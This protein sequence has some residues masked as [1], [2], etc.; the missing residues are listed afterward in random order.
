MPCASCAASAGIS[1][2]RPER[3]L[4]CAQVM[5]DNLSGMMKAA[6]DT[7]VKMAF[8][9]C[10][11]WGLGGCLTTGKPQRAP[12]CAR[13]PTILGSI[14]LPPYSRP[15]TAMPGILF[16]SGCGIVFEPGR[17]SRVF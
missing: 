13:I 11:L 2:L 12:C 6:T 8:V 15:Q 16:L 7:F 14:H 5:R 9:F 4:T 10:L 17:V 3:D 1:L